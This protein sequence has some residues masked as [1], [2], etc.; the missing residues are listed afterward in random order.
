[1][2]QTSSPRRTQRVGWPGLAICGL[3]WPAGLF[4]QAPPLRIVVPTVVVTAQKEPADGQKLPVSVTAVSK[5]TI[6]N[7]GIAIISDAGIY[8]PNTYFS[9]FSARKLSFPRFR[10][11]SSGPGNPAITTYIDGVPQL[12]TSASSLELLDVEQIELVRG[13]QSA[14]F[15]RNALG[16]LVNV[17]SVRPSLTNW[18]GTISAPFGNF[19]S[20]EVRGTVSGPLADRLAIGVA[21]GRSNRDGFTTNDVTGKTIDDRSAVLG[22]VQLLWTPAASWEARAIVSGERVRDGDYALND[23]GALRRDPFHAARDF[24]GRTDRDVASTTVLARRVG[25]RVVFST[26]TG[27]V[28]WR[29]HDLTDLD[30][31]PLPLVRRDNS[32]KAAQFTQEV[33]VASGAMPVRLSD[34]ATLKWQAGVFAFRQ[35]YDQDAINV[36][37][38]FVLDLSIPFAVNQHSPKST[39]DDAGVGVYGQGTMTLHTNLDVTL[40]ARLDHERKSATLDT[41]FE[42]QLPFTTHVSADRNFSDVS[43]Q[44]A[45]AY[46]FAPER[47]GYLSVGRGYKAGG[48]NAASPLGREAYGEEHAWHVEGG[49]KSSWAAGKVIAN[50]AVFHIDWK[51][52]QLNVPNPAVPAQFYIANVGDA[53]SSG[54]EIELTARPHANV[55]VF[56]VLGYTRAR[57]GDGSVSSGLDVS[58]HELPTSPEYTATFGAQYSR[59][60]RAGATFY[61]RGEAVLYGSFFYDDANSASQDAY[62]LT[63]LRTGVRAKYVFAEAW[64][65]NAFD[66][67][68]IPIVFPYGS[69]SGF[70]GEM[71]R[72][73]TFGV[74]VGATF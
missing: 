47:M 38:P 15:G 55:D 41:F 6:A 19:G 32:E 70:I 35:G 13:A 24:E 45:V 18:T 53:R 42:P 57:F 71:G 21:A 52:L 64:V 67:R 12:H 60:V 69:P 61:G 43:P 28:K 54:V 3:L 1:M 23:L 58:Q 8:A 49:M 2:I 37:S 50:A 11:V 33:R 46:R 39:L 9:E 59:A 72:P 56:G 17:A 16:G 65:R 20:K 62:S 68:Y 74:S 34:T 66:T 48:F 5:D 27:V 22:K 26:T 36:F 44:A 4:A 7:E 63:N 40:G 30:Y 25:P 10:G 29:T 14:L 73:R 51:E 31:T